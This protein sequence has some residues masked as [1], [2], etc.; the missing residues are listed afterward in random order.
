MKLKLS[1]DNHSLKNTPKSDIHLEIIAKAIAKYPRELTLEEIVRVID[2]GY[3]IS[4]PIYRDGRKKKDNII[5]MQLFILDFDGKDGCELKYTDALKRADGYNLPVVTSYETKSSVDFSRYRLIFLYNEPVKDIRMME[6]IN[7]MLLKVFPEA[8]QTTKDISKMF[9][10]G[11]NVRLHCGKP[12]YLDSLIVAARHHILNVTSASKNKWACFLNSLKERHGLV[13]KGTDIFTSDEIN[14]QK[15]CTFR[16][17]SIHYYMEGATK[18]QKNGGIKYIFFGETPC[19]DIKNTETKKLRIKNLDIINEE[20]M[21]MSGFE[22]GNRLKH[23]EW[24]GLATNFINIKGGQKKFIDTINKYSD[25]YGNTDFKTAQ[26]KYAARMNYK[27]QSCDSY[28]PY[29]DEC[30]HS[31]NLVSTLKTKRHTMKRIP[32][33]MERFT[34][35]EAARKQCV[36]FFHNA[37]SNGN[38]FNILKSPTGSGKSTAHLEFLKTLDHRTVNAY[39]NARLMLEKYNE[40]VSMGINAVHTPIIEEL[41]SNLA[42]EQKETIKSL[43]EIGA[44]ELPIRLLKKWSHNNPFIQKYLYELDNIPEDAHI[45]TTHSRLF[46]LSASI[47]ENSYIF[48]DEDI[49]PSMISCSAVS[50]DE[51]HK[52]YNIASSTVLKYKLERIKKNISAESHYFNLAKVNINA[53]FKEK[54]TELFNKNGIVFSQNIWGLVE[55]ENFYYCEAD[56]SIHFSVVNRLKNAEKVIVMSATANEQICRTVFGNSLYFCDTGEIKYKGK[57]I[58]HCD[59]SFSRTYL[60]TNNAEK[61]LGE[62]VDKHGDCAY[63]TFKEYCKYIDNNYQKTHYGQAI[64]TNDFSGNDLVIIGLNHRPFYVYELFARELGIDCSDSL[65]TRKTSFCGFEYYMMTYEN[66][67]LCNIQQYMISSDLEQAIG[68]A[69]LIY[70]D[71]TVHLYGNFPARQGRFEREN[72]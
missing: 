52:L 43:Y 46:R 70:H 51:F 5:E 6:I 60:K 25:L 11:R 4:S 40:A 49:I 63:I 28:C 35:I 18:V 17:S 72:E 56:Q 20:C 33:Y 67:D 41:Y 64:G 36:A 57:V 19:N 12:F 7:S 3:T 54:M 30:V 14:P 15:I 32:G 38:R 50:V 34:E 65:S 68:R 23:H 37:V 10:P 13:I 22:N 59:K 21:L 42:D 69:R 31:V 53:D 66:A 48:I 58:M 71:C 44:G 45:F 61:L 1:V 27:P 47:T 16:A 55:S 9:F 62:I 39:P 26:V 2:D 24:F 8:D 29:A